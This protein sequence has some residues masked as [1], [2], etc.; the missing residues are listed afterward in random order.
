MVPVR[1]GTVIHRASQGTGTQLLQGTG[2]QLLQVCS[3]Q[4]LRL[5]TVRRPS[6]LCAGRHGGCQALPSGVADAQTK[7]E[8]NLGTVC[9]PHAAA[10]GGRIWP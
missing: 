4:G 5:C 1:A 7:V 9:R 10:L 6:S 2:M 3:N 8:P